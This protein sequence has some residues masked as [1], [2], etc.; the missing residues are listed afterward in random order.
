MRGGDR[1]PHAATRCDTSFFEYGL[2]DLLVKTP[3]GLISAQYELYTTGRKLLGPGC[4][5][6]PSD[7]L[8]RASRKLLQ[9]PPNASVPADYN[10]DQTK[11]ED[12]SA[13]SRSG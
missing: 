2:Q 7:L 1:A 9:A 3:W 8:A 13:C 12:A 5:R 10:A 6:A 11:G 4:G